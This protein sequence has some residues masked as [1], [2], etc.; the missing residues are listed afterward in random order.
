MFIRINAA[1]DAS[2]ARRDDNEKG[3]TLIELLVVV[4]I[5]GILSAIAIPIFLGQQNQA[6]EAA[7]KSDLTNLK[8]AV[9][10]YQTAHNGTYPTTGVPTGTQL[11]ELQ[12]FG[13]VQSDNTSASSIKSTA[14]LCLEATSTTTTVYHLGATGGVATG[15]C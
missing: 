4:L 3:F 2:R 1:L 12:G 6:K 15:A 10:S 8:V 9:I 11:T 14:P 5:I 13:F 7:T